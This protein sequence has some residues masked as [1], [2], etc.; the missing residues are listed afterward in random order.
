MCWHLYHT[1]GCPLGWYPHGRVVLDGTCMTRLGS[2]LCWYLYYTVEIP[3]FG[4]RFRFVHVHYFP[5]F[6]APN[7][8]QPL[9][10][11]STLVLDFLCHPTLHIYKYWSPSAGHISLSHTPVIPL[12]Q[13]LV[14]QKALPT[15]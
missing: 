4:T 15:D 5:H 2:S 7:A 11:S 13:L 14:L 3:L 10:G 6:A 12:S 1:L 9:H 8:P